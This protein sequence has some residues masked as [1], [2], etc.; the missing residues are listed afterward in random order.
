MAVIV[1]TKVFGMTA[2]ELARGRAFLHQAGAMEGSLPKGATINV[3]SAI[4]GGH[5][6][7]DTWNAIEDFHAF[8]ETG[9]I[10][11][12]EALGFDHKREVEI[13]EVFE[14]SHALGE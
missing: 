13:S 2:D 12:E 1:I 4:E 7:V 11:M 3:A 6:F 8:R 14:I 9:L 10:P 5:Q